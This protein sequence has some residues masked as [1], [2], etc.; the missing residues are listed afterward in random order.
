MK[1]HK[2]FKFMGFLNIL[3]EA[4]I[5]T[6]PRTWEKWISIIR[7]KYGKKAN[8]PKWWVSQLFWV[9]QKSIVR[10]KYGKTLTFQSNGFL[11]Y[12][13][14][15]RNPYNSQNMGKVNLHSTRKERENTE[16]SDSLRYLADLEFTRTRRFPNVF[17][18]TNSHKMEIFCEK[19]YHSQAV[20]F[21]G[22]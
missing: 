12:F 6:I 20:G 9:K 18:C 8:I 11:K 16:I 15:N 2:H 4:E 14:R 3:D 17:E 22:S 13:G 10:E 1:K 19:P 21:W 5:Y 7:E